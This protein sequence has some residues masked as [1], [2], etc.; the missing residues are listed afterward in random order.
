VLGPYH[1]LAPIGRGGTSTVY[2]AR[3]TRSDL[4]IALKVLPPQRAREEERILARFRREMELCQRVAHP[5]IAWTHEVGVHRG[6]Y[7][8]AMEYI[9]GRN[10]FRLVQEDGLLPVPRAARLF[11]EIAS[12]LDHAH[13]QG[14]IHRDLK[15]S[16]IIVT[17]HDH[18]KLLDLGLALM[19][20]E[21]AGDRTVIGGQGYIVGTMDYLAPEQAEDSVAVDART[22]IYSLGCTLYYAL[23]GIQPFAGGSKMDKI[24]RHR[25]EEPTPIPDIN[26]AVPAAFVGVVRRMMAKRPG[27]RYA[28]AAELREELLAW[29]SGEAM[30]LDRQDDA[31]YRQAVAELEAAPTTEELLAEVI[32][33]GI[34]VAE[35]RPRRRPKPSANGS[36]RA[37]YGPAQLVVM[38][39]WGL[40]IVTFLLACLL[41]LHR[42]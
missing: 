16:N 9:P 7:Y 35:R 3:D 1:V 5:H 11:A 13:N 33:V 37:E 30:P 17:P 18:A 32:P 36:A 20:G 39:L 15:P 14:L 8:I 24:R 38:G 29:G 21:N 31:E 10:L 41:Y 22:D 23:T 12:A 25:G 19:E 28:S 4:L 40:V 2:L 42:G 34:P 27:Q 6:V 26:P